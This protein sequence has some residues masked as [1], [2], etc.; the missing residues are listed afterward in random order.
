[1]LECGE[2]IDTLAHRRFEGRYSGQLLVQN[3]HVE[4]LVTGTGRLATF[5]ESVCERCLG[6][7]DV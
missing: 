2:L 1:M 5:A 7:H 4:G 6:I 3:Q